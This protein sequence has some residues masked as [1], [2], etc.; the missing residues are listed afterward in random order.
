[1]VTRFDMGRAWS[2]TTAF[3]RS[4]RQQVWLIAGLFLFLPNLLLGWFGPQPPVPPAGAGA[5]AAMAMMSDYY[6]A[7]L[8]F[9][10]L[11]GVLAIFANL[12]LWR[13][14]L[15][16][17]GEE[18][19]TALAA[20]AGGFLPYLLVSLLTIIPLMIGFLLLVVPGLYLLARLCVVGPAIAS[21]N[22]RN[23]LAVISASW[24]ATQK[25]A[26]PILGFLIIVGLVMIILYLIVASVTGA[27]FGFALPA[28]LALW[29]TKPVEA[30]LQM[31][32]GLI[33]AAMAAAIWHQ[34]DD[35][36]QA[37]I[38]A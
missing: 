2:D 28:D 19:G 3:L 10:M 18:T 27:V 29:L 35:S 25:T 11:A 33:Q 5:D 14:W 26:W 22:L 15:G 13:V 21:Q 23:P 37:D 24:R 7:A 30:L 32:M 12:A 34:V 1:M 6:M 38:F 9:I 31:A 4:D 17:Q 8:P 20:A 16:R 36:D